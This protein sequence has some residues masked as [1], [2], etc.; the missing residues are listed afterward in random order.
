M[1]TLFK[2]KKQKQSET[3]EIIAEIHETFFT[4]VDRLLSEARVSKAENDEKSSLIEKADRLK[5]LG[6]SQ[7]I[8]TK[9]GHR[10]KEQ[11]END[12]LLIEAIEYFSFKYPQYKFI[13][14]E[15][16]IKICEKYNLIYG[17]VKRYLG[18]I[19]DYNLSQIERFQISEEDKA[20]LRVT[21]S[22]FS[23]S[24]NKYVS[25]NEYAS[26]PN[27]HSRSAFGYYDNCPLEICAPQKDFNTDGMEIKNSQLSKIE[28][29][30]PVVLQPVFYK[31][32]KFYL[33]VTAWG[34]EANDESVQNPK[35]N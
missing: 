16:V 3:L 32:K 25:Y 31:N 8:E 10:I 9:N 14:D 33:I 22:L 2:T 7:S 20:Y 26:Y 13:T 30:D 21:V 5:K 6:F 18:T 19:P 4:E 29:P 23:G 1:I 28:I 17:S 24:E 27:S 35:L 12:K 34:L 11:S 15:S